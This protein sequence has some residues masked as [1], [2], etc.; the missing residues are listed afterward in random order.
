MR[1]LT[2][3]PS[4]RP[5]GTP[6]DGSAASRPGPA[7][8]SP[9]A[10]LL[11]VG[12]CVVGWG[13]LVLR[14]VE[15]APA[16]PGASTVLKPLPITDVQIRGGKRVA[17]STIRE[18][19]KIQV[20]DTFSAQAV[21]EDVRA[22]RDLGFFLDVVAKVEDFAGG[23]RLI[24]E[25]VERPT[26][27]QVTFEGNKRFDSARLS[28]ETELRPGGYLDFYLL[29]VA[30]DRIRDLYL[31]EGHQFVEV[32][33]EVTETDDEYQVSFVIVEGPKVRIKEVRVEGNKAFSDGKIL[34]LLRTRPYMFI[35]RKGIYDPG[36]LET[37]LL[38]VTQ[39]YTRAGYMDVAV[40]RQLSYSPDKSELFI[41]I[42]IDEGPLY[43]VTEVILTGNKAV[44][45][46]EIREA[47]TLRQG[48]YYNQEAAQNNL[49]SIYELYG[50]R[51]YVPGENLQVT[52]QIGFAVE[53]GT[54]TIEYR[55]EEGEPLYVDQVRIVGNYK[56]RDKVVRRDLTFYP[57]ELLNSTELRRSADRL[58]GRGYYSKVSLDLIP[59]STDHSRTAIVTVEEDQTALFR[60]GAGVSSNSGLIGD[61]SFVQRNFDWTKVPRS[62]SDFLDGTAFAGAGQYLRFQFQPGTE[63]SM[64]RVDFTEPWL[65]DRPYSLGLSGWL[66]SRQREDFDE[67]RRGG[68]VSFGHRFIPELSVKGTLKAEAVEINDIELGTAPDVLAVAGSSDLVSL[69]GDITYDKR[70]N[71]WVP[72]KGYLLGAYF[73]H[74]GKFLGGDVDI[75]K[76]GLEG[77]F[78]LTVRTDRFGRKHVLAISGQ[79]DFSDTYGGGRVPIFER[80]FA[81]GAHSVR[82]FEF[83]GLGPHFGDQPL[84]GETRLLGSVEYSFPLAAE[85]LRGLLFWDVGQVV[86]TISGLE[87]GEFRNA[88]GFGLRITA[89][90]LGPVPIAL[91]FGFPLDAKDEDEKQVFSF[92]IGA[93]F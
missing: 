69:R 40:D 85:A 11:L 22:V 28:K 59:G 1:Q 38:R 57:G 58:R 12:L 35:F 92:S 84:G 3:S 33:K 26:L 55:F 41:T 52:P 89:P 37:D 23:Y 25:V 4:E 78:F 9:V 2:T 88:V 83:R 6:P 29:G 60:F 27:T 79:A 20:G 32:T 90:G 70:D 63:L 43:K 21:D 36:T 86:P 31:A 47:L 67:Q 42:T 50:A 44:S 53:P 80:F 46:R 13:L 73:E 93:A 77:Q 91:D 30:E 39:F 61:I 48:E 87:L 71:W 16:V 45:G 34:G 49:R 19:M 8:R 7:P 66:F 56:T 72:S 54:L 17:T 65:F 75:W 64:F 76:A 51:G 14:P 15:G 82:G 68:S 18:A 5:Q 62:L 24:I 74:Y 10:A 81:G